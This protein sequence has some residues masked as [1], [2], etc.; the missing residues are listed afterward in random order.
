MADLPDSGFT[1]VNDVETAVGAPVSEALAQ[2]YGSNENYLNTVLS[3]SMVSSD[4]SGNYSTTS[5]SYVDVTN[6]TL[7]IT[8]IG[9]PI[10]VGLISDGTN[11][12]GSLGTNAGGVSSSEA[13]FRLL[14]DSTVIAQCRVSKAAS[15]SSGSAISVP[16]GAL[17]IID[18]PTAGT[19]TYKVQARRGVS[20]TTV[21]AQYCK[22]IALEL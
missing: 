6:L 2:R 14:R 22:L 11:D 19:Y 4:S 13:N 8:S 7:N 16:P 20:S 1:N 9:R 21:L 5:S 10:Y 15:S 12:D 17:W 18:A 3:R